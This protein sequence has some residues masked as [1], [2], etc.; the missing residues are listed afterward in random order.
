MSAVPIKAALMPR[1]RRE[2]HL[3]EDPVALVLSVDVETK[4]ISLDI[5]D[6]LG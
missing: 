4:A 5:I 3:I 6:E 1:P 2:I